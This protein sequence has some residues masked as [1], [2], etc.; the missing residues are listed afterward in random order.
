MVLLGHFSSNY[1][2]DRIYMDKEQVKVVQFH[3]IASI[4]TEF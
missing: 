1:N 4:P 3:T 2:H